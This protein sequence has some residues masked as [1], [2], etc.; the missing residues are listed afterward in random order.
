MG[1]AAV[2][3]FGAREEGEAIL[4]AAR[5][6]G[7]AGACAALDERA[8]PRNTVHGAAAMEAACCQAAEEKEQAADRENFP[9]RGAWSRRGA[10]GR[11][12]SMTS[13]YTARERKKKS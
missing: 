7:D 8:I 3:S 1:H 13:M 10:C 5:L 9:L 12:G 2:V 11:R 6:R 4:P